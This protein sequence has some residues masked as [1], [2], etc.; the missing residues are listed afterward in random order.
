MNERNNEFTR[1]AITL[2]V[3]KSDTNREPNTTRYDTKLVG[4]GLRL[5][6]FVSYLGWND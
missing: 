2:G 1:K 6:G 5:N 4:Y 3:T